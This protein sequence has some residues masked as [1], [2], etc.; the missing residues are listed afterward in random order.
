MAPRVREV[1]IDAWSWL[2]YK[3]LMANPRQPGGALAELASKWVPDEDLRRLAVYKLMAAYDQGQAGQLAAATSGESEQ[4]DRREL[5]DPAKLIDTT[6]GYLLGTEQTIV[7][8]QAEHADDDNPPEGAAATADL[9]ERLRGWAQKEL[10]ELR[11]QQAERAAVRCGDG[12]YALAWEPSKGRVLFR[13]Y[14]PGFFFPKWPEEAEQDGAT[15]RYGSTSRG[16]CPR[17]PARA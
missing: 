4:A 7:V 6:L 1:V 3:P 12:V 8:P 14:D 10:L 16:S 5:G 13:T 17:T 11:M 9:Q 15:S 2:N